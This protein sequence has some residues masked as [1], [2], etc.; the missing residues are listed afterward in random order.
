MVDFKMYMLTEKVKGIVKDELSR[1]EEVRLANIFNK[2]HGR[3][4]INSIT[5]DAGKGRDG[6][7]VVIGFSDSAHVKARFTQRFPDMSAKDIKR[8]IKTIGLGAYRTKPEYFHTGHTVSILVFS[9]SKDI[10]MYVV[11]EKDRSGQFTF[12]LVTILPK[13]RDNISRDSDVKLI[14]ES[15]ENE[16]LTNSQ[17]IIYIDEASFNES[18]LDD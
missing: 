16:Y 15:M 13:G 3:N 5:V 8:I 9:K 7:N 2:K 14:V 1:E 10:G 6:E 4:F 18:E 12:K 11:Y 17:S